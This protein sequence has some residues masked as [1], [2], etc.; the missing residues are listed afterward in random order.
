MLK[1]TLFVFLTVFSLQICAYDAD[2]A[3]QISSDII[4][5]Y[6]TQVNLI[7]PNVS[8]ITWNNITWTIKNSTIT[9]I[10]TT[11]DQGRKLSWNYENQT[12]SE[13]KSNSLIPI[14]EEVS[15]KIT[16]PAQPI[17][18]DMETILHDRFGITPSN[19]TL[20]KKNNQ[21][22]GSGIIQKKVPI[23]TPK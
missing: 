22:P 3:P 13:F 19:K 2:N 21:S 17:T 7:P 5:N 8:V 1:K 20:D 12:F 14:P 23:Q 9:G 6:I 18:K 16:K 10:S 11:D 15:K 4:N